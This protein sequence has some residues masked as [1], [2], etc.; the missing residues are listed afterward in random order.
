MGDGFA[1]AE[2]VAN[3]SAAN[4]A[5]SR[6]PLT[7][8]RILLYVMLCA[9]GVLTMFPFF[10]MLLTS[11]KL[12]GDVFKIPPSFVPTKLFSSTPFG[13][14]TDLITKFSFARYLLNSVFVSSA[15]SVG[16]LVTCSLA[17]FAFAR[18]RFPARGLLFGALIFTM[19]VPTEVAIIPEF[20]LM[21]KLGWLDT[22]LPLIIPSLMIGAFGTFMLTEFFRTVP[23]SLEEAA[24]IDG[25]RPFSIYW[26]LFLPLSLPVLAS[27]FVIA[28]IDNWNQLLRP[29]LYISSND[30]RTIPLGL[31]SLQGQ[32]QSQ[33]TLLM[34]GSIVSITPMIIIYLA[35]QKYIVQ[36]FV[37]SGL[38]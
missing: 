35:A 17:G 23:R 14:Y 5:V 19:F 38:K 1:T 36:G 34:A 9:A 33:W 31:I 18:M 20:L 37:T 26:N 11:F 15:A 24:T 16:Q 25:A 13:N 3:P 27:L 30:L 10:W 12:P 8:S 4:T 32:Y 29:V 21:V 28:F 6:K 2:A 22:Y 7:L